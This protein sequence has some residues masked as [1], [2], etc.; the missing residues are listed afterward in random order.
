MEHEQDTRHPLDVM[1]EEAQTIGDAMQRF[2]QASL[3]YNGRPVSEG[4]TKELPAGQYRGLASYLRYLHT[5]K[6]VRTD[7]AESG[8]QGKDSAGTHDG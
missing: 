4:M 7:V 5:I 3:V 2:N 1:S 6:D 8:A